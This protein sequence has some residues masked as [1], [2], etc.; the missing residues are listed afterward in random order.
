MMRMRDSSS[1][2]K[3]KGSKFELDMCVGRSAGFPCRCEVAIIILGP[4]E[5]Y[6]GYSPEY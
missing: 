4:A 3:W 5:H 1:E 6:F 2:I